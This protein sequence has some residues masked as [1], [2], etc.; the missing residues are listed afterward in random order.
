[1]QLSRIGVISG[2]L[3]SL[4]SSSPA[5]AHD[6]SQPVVLGAPGHDRPGPPPIITSAKIGTVLFPYLMHA[7]DAGAYTEPTV[8]V[9]TQHQGH[10]S[11]TTSFS[12]A[13]FDWPA[14]SG[15]WSL[16]QEIYSHRECT[17][18]EPLVFTLTGLEADASN[19]DTIEA[20]LLSIVTELAGLVDDRIDSDLLAR[21]IRELL[22][23]LN[24]D[25][26]LGTGSV[27]AP[28]PGVYNITTAGGDY[29]IKA[30][31]I[32]S[33]QVVTGG[34]C[35][36]DSIP[37]EDTP[38]PPC[39]FS[40]AYFDRLTTLWHDI[41]NIAIESGNPGA[42]TA[43]DLADAKTSLR[44]M[45]VQSACWTAAHMVEDARGLSGF[46]S[47]LFYLLQ[48][49]ANPTVG[50]IT[51][52]RTAFCTAEFAIGNNIRDPNAPPM[53]AVRVA[54]PSFIATRINRT[55]EFLIGVFD[56]RS[57]AN[58]ASVTGGPPG[59]QV[60]ID[61]PDPGHPSWQI[62][63]VS[64]NGPPGQYTLT[65]NFTGATLSPLALILD[66]DEP[67][68]V[69]V[70]EP[71]ANRPSRFDL[72]LTRNPVA[73]PG[74]MYLDLPL[75]AQLTIT[76]Y[77]VAGRQVRRLLDHETRG[78]GQ[79]TLVMNADELAP[80]IYFVRMTAEPVD[81][82]AAFSKTVRKMVVAR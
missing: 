60:T 27:T 77:D 25:D 65:V 49:S 70:I 59:T 53:P 72:R 78:A 39:Y 45:A 20:A 30:S 57:G 48:G 6:D 18:M 36:P 35:D 23:I 64:Q 17:P 2:V 47:A 61:T 29:S 76:V 37:Q 55:A 62:L 31:F 80:G 16:F 14:N 73:G 33:T 69:D 32:V 24:P 79:H 41:D 43:Q 74:V 15:L 12:E 28:A 9:A 13:A 8:T 58:I 26:T 52:F 3:I 75:V 63:R 38:P 1:M 82:G 42:V 51:D 10:G 46:S 11:R 81:G 7:N 54:V 4:V 40:A 50:A 22:A 5:V 21:I 66:I 34:E 56:G 19:L 68:P 67:T 44:S 71:S